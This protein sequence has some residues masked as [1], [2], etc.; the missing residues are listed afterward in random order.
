MGTWDI[1]HV[2]HKKKWLLLMSDEPDVEAVD[3][4]NEIALETSG[5]VVVWTKVDRLLGNYQD[6]GGKPAQKA[7]ARKVVELNEHVAEI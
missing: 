2:M 6:P 4:L 1:D 7:L 5:T 3:H